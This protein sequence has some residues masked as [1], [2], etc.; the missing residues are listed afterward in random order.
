MQ[1]IVTT[2]LPAV[3][4]S[5][6]VGLRFNKEAVVYPHQNPAISHRELILSDKLLL[7]AYWVLRRVHD[8]WWLW[9]PFLSS[10]QTCAVSSSTVNASQQGSIQLS[11]NLIP[12]CSV[13]KVFVVFSNRVLLYI[14]YSFKCLQTLLLLL[15]ILSL[16]IVIQIIIALSL[17]H[18][19]IDRVGGSTH[20]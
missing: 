9:M 7:L 1:L 19:H 15:I 18:T 16:Q 13:S 14:D 4:F 3:Y 5:H 12:L 2:F 20:L 17:R 6:R 11:S 8:F 10:P